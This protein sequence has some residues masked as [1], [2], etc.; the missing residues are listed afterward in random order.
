M[1]RYQESEHGESKVN[2][3]RVEGSRSAIT[4]TRIIQDSTCLT[5]KKKIKQLSWMVEP[6][7]TG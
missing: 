7:K 5:W 3:V 6:S 1:G 2:M 4:A